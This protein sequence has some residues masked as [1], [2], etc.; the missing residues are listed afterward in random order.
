MHTLHF[1]LIQSDRGLEAGEVFDLASDA[2]ESYQDEV[3]DWHAQGSGRWTQ[4]YPAPL[5]FREDPQEFFAQLEQISNAR[6]A[7]QQEALAHLSHQLGFDVEAHPQAIGQALFGNIDTQVDHTLWAAIH[8]L[9]LARGDYT[10]DSAFYDA[11]EGSARIPDPE[12]INAMTLAETE[13]LYLVPMD[14][15][16]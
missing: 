1:I 3:F 14:L 13:D 5:S 4:E 9:K 10:I 11:I 8:Y 16:C 12:K 15:H 6:L 7:K 2:I